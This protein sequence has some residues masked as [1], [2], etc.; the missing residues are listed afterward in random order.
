VLSPI[1]FMMTHDRIVNRKIVQAFSDLD[2]LRRV[3]KLSVDE[4][5]WPWGQVLKVARSRVPRTG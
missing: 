1:G 2:F 3:I 5:H 4:R